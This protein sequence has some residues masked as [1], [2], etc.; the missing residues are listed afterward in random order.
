M[1]IKG[2]IYSEM[3]PECV[4]LCRAINAIT[5]LQTLLS[6]CGHGER[7]FRI[8]FRPIKNLNTL[9]ILLYFCD[10]CH[11]GFRWNCLLETDCAMS[12]VSFRIESEA[13]GDEAYR[14]AKVI[15]KEIRRYLRRL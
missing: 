14:Q 13:K 4:D 9:S 2:K 6:C 5:N 3:D 1:K 15:A 10:P 8:W 7:P 12:P 11:V